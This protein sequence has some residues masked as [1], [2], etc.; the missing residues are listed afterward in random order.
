MYNFTPSAHWLYWFTSAN[1]HLLWWTLKC[2][3]SFLHIHLDQKHLKQCRRF[4]DML[5]YWDYKK[6]K[7][8]SPSDKLCRGGPHGKSVSIGKDTSSITNLK[9]S[10]PTENWI[11]TELRGI[12]PRGQ[13]ISIYLLYQCFCRRWGKCVGW[14]H[15]RPALSACV[16]APRMPSRSF[17]CFSRESHVVVKMF[18]MCPAQRCKIAS[19]SAIS[20][21]VTVA[22]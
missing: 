1:S 11:L 13:T 15:I 4:T 18:I 14:Y 16:A 20:W 19:V 5:I 7:N 9:Y 6:T 21:A 2:V 22:V 17:Q 12:L 10:L 8:I 3:D